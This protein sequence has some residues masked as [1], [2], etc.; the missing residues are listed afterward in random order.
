MQ[1]SQD[2]SF[3]ATFEDK[4]LMSDIVFLRA[5]IGVDLPKFYNPVTNLLAPPVRPM[6][7]QLKP[8]HMASEVITQR[9]PCR[10]CMLLLKWL[11]QCHWK[12]RSLHMLCCVFDDAT[13]FLPEGHTYVCIY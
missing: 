2:G 10:H 4:P 8:G 12:K 13:M 5:W 9:S 6:A 1:N 3:R 7:R 11:Q